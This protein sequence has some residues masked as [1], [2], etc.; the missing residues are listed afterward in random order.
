MLKT[1]KSL[2]ILEFTE[3]FSTDDKCKEYLSELK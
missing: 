1:F 3:K 2:N